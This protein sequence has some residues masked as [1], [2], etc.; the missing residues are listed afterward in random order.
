MS[1]GPGHIQRKIAEVF[2][3]NPD[4]AFTVRMLCKLVWGDPHLWPEPVQRS[5]VLRAAGKV[6][7][8]A[9]WVRSSLHFMANETCFVS[10]RNQ[11]AVGLKDALSQ[12]AIAEIMGVSERTIRRDLATKAAVETLRKYCGPG[13]C[14]GPNAAVE[15]LRHEP[16]RALDWNDRRPVGRSTDRS[17]PGKAKSKCGNGNQD[18]H[19]TFE[20]T[21]TVGANR[22][23]MSIADD[24]RF[25]CVWSPHL[26]GALSPSDWAH[27]TLSFKK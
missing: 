14:T 17:I 3:G 22:A 24:G 5:A 8:K 26:P 15:T 13:T 21:F 12:R 7:R 23:K 27:E 2:A 4:K 18:R 20:R 11:L 25:K 19:M 1:R 16:K 10:A 6:A 9:G